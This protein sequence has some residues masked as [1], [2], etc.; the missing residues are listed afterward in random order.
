MAVAVVSHGTSCAVPC[1]LRLRQ[2]GFSLLLHAHAI[3]VRFLFVSSSL[4]E[5]SD[6]GPARAGNE[7]VF[8]IEGLMTSIWLKN[9]F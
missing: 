2:S 3:S 7:A 1:G 5:R 8:R 4:P 9:E 6:E